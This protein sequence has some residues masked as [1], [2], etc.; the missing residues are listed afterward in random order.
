MILIPSTSST[1]FKQRY[2]FT[3]VFQAALLLLYIL[4]TYT[5]D[6]FHSASDLVL[7]AVGLFFANC[8]FAV[9]AYRREYKM[10]KDYLM[11]C[12]LE[13]EEVRSQNLLLRML[14][15]SV[16]SKLRE[17]SEFIYYKHPAV[18]L[19]FSHISDFDE[20]VH[21]MTAMQ[22]IR[23]LNALF[24]QFDLLTD[25]HGVYK[26]ETIGDVYLVAAG[27]PIEYVREDH[28]DA[29][30]SFALD[31]VAAAK[32]F[33][34]EHVRD[35]KSGST[36]VV[37]PRSKHHG[38]RKKHGMGHVSKL[39]PIQLQLGINCG[40]I[41]SGVVGVKYPRFRLMGDTI[42]TASRMSTTATAGQIQMST[43]AWEALNKK[44]FDTKYRGDVT[45]KGKGVMKTYL[46]LGRVELIC[47]PPRSLEE[48][49]VA[50]GTIKLDAFKS[51]PEDKPART[52]G[53]ILIDEPV[54]RTSPVIHPTHIARG[55][56][57]HDMLS[58]DTV[59]EMLP[60]ELPG[61]PEMLQKL[62]SGEVG[63]SDD[64]SEE[65]DGVGEKLVERSETP[66]SLK[67]M[68][69]GLADVLQDAGGDGEIVQIVGED[70]L[71]HAEHVISAEGEEAT[72]RA[73]GS[74]QPTGRQGGG[75][76]GRH[77]AGDASPH[78][79]LSPGG[80]STTALSP[81]PAAG[82]RR[83]HNISNTSLMT[84][85]GS[86]L[87]STQTL[88]S[89]SHSDPFHLSSDSSHSSLSLTNPKVII[90]ALDHQ[91]TFKSIRLFS[92]GPMNAIL[93]P[94]RKWYHLLSQTFITDPML[95]YEYRHVY[96]KDYLG[97][98]RNVVN[99]MWIFLLPLSIYDGLNNTE[100]ES[101]L[102]GYSWLIR[103]FGLGVGIWFY[104]F[105]QRP[106]YLRRMQEATCFTVTTVG[107]VYIVT[108]TLT[109]AL[110][111]SYGVGFVLM[112]LCLVSMFLGLRFYPALISCSVIMLSWIIAA[113][114]SEGTVPGIVS[115]LIAGSV[116]YLET[117]WNMENESR[118]DFV[119]FRKLNHERMSTHSF[120]SNMLPPVVFEGLKREDQALVAHERM[121]ADVLFSDI[122][123]FTSIAATLKP[124][125]V[126][127]V[128]NVMFATF[129]SCSVRYG[130]Y[131]V[132]TIGDAYVACT[133]VVEIR[134][135]HTRCLVEFALA[136]QRAT[137]SMFT[138]TH[139]QIVIRVGIHTGTVIAGVVGRKMPRYHLFGETVTLAELMEQKGVPGMVA[140]SQA[141]F[142]AMPPESLGEYDIKALEPVPHGDSKIS[143]WTI[144]KAKTTGQGAISGDPVLAGKNRRASVRRPNGQ[145]FGTP[146]TPVQTLANSPIAVYPTSLAH[147]AP[148]DRDSDSNSDKSR[149]SGKKTPSVAPLSPEGEAFVPV[150]DL[151]VTVPVFLPGQEEPTFL[152]E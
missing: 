8:L 63:E 107:V 128:L 90:S 30:A 101:S 75:I 134:S 104:H 65:S 18:T 19:L 51:A 2:I 149:E 50:N 7:T 60:T 3:V 97:I 79:P 23:M 119:R 83:T 144:E 139:Q 13:K 61:V 95:E 141:A 28:V 130:V 133:N 137:K 109:S 17:G 146:K 69:D 145:S 47:P 74:E 88:S 72:G 136:I 125:D 12:Q 43:K 147:A 48:I 24:T 64:E 151:T 123:G 126:V 135:D 150:K 9:H 44:W 58:P 122:V 82:K 5:F 140:F 76:S 80:G 78:S 93:R 54:P 25:I 124:E 20:H 45:V 142:Q 4:I 138:P 6:S 22:V 92:F 91:S 70:G 41:I 111:K 85:T 1:L 32:Q 62:R 14:P 81:P 55:G 94:E 118:H 115:V 103:L 10:R 34:V 127:A 114:V 143:R 132:E 71:P 53:G 87:S 42:N 56:S 105:S 27:C 84:K 112:T 108:A 77:A 73:P 68:E 96:A 35:V 148:T 116:M 110:L 40:T 33:M 16:I 98:N 11:K 99:F 121:D 100:L 52:H 37:D 113:G 117:N 26:V 21:S 67:A 66:S 120:L 39:C 29:I 152:P 86:M 57:S 38:Y 131:K 46:L 102:V 89:T 15:A 36:E 106:Q 129:D 49:Q 59:V 31:M